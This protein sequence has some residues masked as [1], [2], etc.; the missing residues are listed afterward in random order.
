MSDKPFVFEDHTQPPSQE[1]LIQQFAEKLFTD[2]GSSGVFYGLNAS[3]IATA[4]LIAAETMVWFASVANDVSDEDIV[5]I[6]NK[7]AETVK[8]KIKDLDNRGITKLLKDTKAQ[9]PHFIKV[10]KDG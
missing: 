6:R 8:E 10:K 3:N 5:V 7:V 9:I 2:C 1:S 4:M